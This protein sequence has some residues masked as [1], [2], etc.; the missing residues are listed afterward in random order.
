[1]K[2]PIAGIRGIKPRSAKPEGNGKLSKAEA[3]AL[4]RQYRIERNETLRLKNER[5]RMLL[6]KAQG[7]L[8]SRKDVE[9]GLAFVLV[10]IRSKVL[11]IHRTWA[12]RLAG[13]DPPKVRETL[14]ELELSLLSELRNLE[15]V[16]DPDRLEEEAAD[17]SDDEARDIAT[18]EMPKR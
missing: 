9:R 8:L 4:D 5:E 13:L 14:W 10:A 7:E 6:E 12:H 3:H 2:Q 1:M 17:L 18:S 11:A 15:H 16:T